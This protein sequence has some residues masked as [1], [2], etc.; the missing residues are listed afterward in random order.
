MPGNLVVERKSM[1]E[2]Y[3]PILLSEGHDKDLDLPIREDIGRLNG[4]L[5]WLNNIQDM[6]AAP[7]LADWEKKRENGENISYSEARYILNET[8]D[9]LKRHRSRILFLND[10]FYQK[11]CTQ[12]PEKKQIFQEIRNRLQACGRFMTLKANDLA[13]IASFVADLLESI[14]NALSSDIKFS[15]G[16]ASQLQVLQQQLKADQQAI[17]FTMVWEL[18][19]AQGTFKLEQEQKQ[20]KALSESMFEHVQI[21][22]G[23]N[24][25]KFQEQD[26]KS[27]EELI[28]KTEALL[29][30]INKEQSGGDLNASDLN[31][32]VIVINNNTDQA[33]NNDI[34]AFV[35][36]LCDEVSSTDK[37]L[38]RIYNPARV[39]KID[40]SIVFPVNFSLNPQRNLNA[41]EKTYTHTFDYFKKY[42]L[43]YG[44]D[45]QKEKINEIREDKFQSYFKALLSGKNLINTGGEAVI[46]LAQD[47]LDKVLNYFSWDK[48]EKS[49]S[50]ED[51][52]LQS[53]LFLKIEI[54]SK[55][56]DENA[57]LQGSILN[58]NTFEKIEDNQENKNNLSNSFLGDSKAGFIEIKAIDDKE[59]SKKLSV[60]N[61]ENEAILVENTNW[62]A[63]KKEVVGQLFNG[64][65]KQVKANE[66]FKTLT[67]N[68]K[69]DSK[70]LEKVLELL[71]EIFQEIIKE[72]KGKKRSTG[73]FFT[74][75]NQEYTDHQL[76]K[77]AVLKKVYRRCVEK[78]MEDQNCQKSTFIEKLKNKIEDQED[79]KSLVNFQLTRY[80]FLVSEST[81]NNKNLRNLIR[82]PAEIQQAAYQTAK[83]SR[84][85]F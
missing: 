59:K 14:N 58:S 57:S 29:K 19:I 49:N 62:Y 67:N 74:P 16:L 46:N 50:L 35:S 63:S 47:M 9:T 66:V 43:K 4:Q 28:E 1:F 44:T 31:D 15:E 56:N 52:L 40:T 8:Y 34:M 6:T 18:E 68:C 78:G 25:G 81:N 17:I 21:S 2:T 10:D 45:S 41:D 33:F 38:K 64:A 7:I 42:I 22:S 72:K 76:T 11:L 55:D 20:N 79:R 84:A 26:I 73:C 71:E 82:T 13:G 60:K 48:K 27:C 83:F 51:P 37:N 85:V 32:S 12:Y 3:Q 24:D 5:N 53:H 77:I 65:E 23:E 36:S 54:N 70:N 61:F 30:E 39:N 75:N 69:I 80:K